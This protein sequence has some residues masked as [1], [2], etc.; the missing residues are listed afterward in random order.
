MDERLRG[1]IEAVEAYSRTY[2]QVT[3]AVGHQTDN[4]IVRQ[5][6]AV[7]GLV[8]K[9]LEVI[10]IEAVETIVRSHPERTLPVLAEVVDETAGETVGRNKLS[11]LGQSFEA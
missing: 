9:S 7:G 5:R 3:L 8:N 2:P 10:T 11:R 6:G 1:G 4:H